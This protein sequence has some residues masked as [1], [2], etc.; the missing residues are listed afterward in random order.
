M[1][2]ITNVISNGLTALPDLTDPR[3]G[4]HYLTDPTNSASTPKNNDQ[5]DAFLMN[6]ATILRNITMQGHGGFMQVLDP[7]GQVLTKSPY[8]QTASSFSQ[9]INKQAFRGGMF[10]DGF[11]GNSL[12]N[13]IGTTTPFRIQV[14]S[15]PGQ[16]LRIRRPETPAPFFIQGQ[17]YQIDAV[18]NYDQANGTADLIL[19]ET[20][21]SGNGW[22]GT[23]S[24]PF[25]ISIQTAGNRSLLAND[26]TQIND[27]SLIHI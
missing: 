7:T 3:Y 26:Y 6:D 15:D 23:Y 25:T 14:Q 24:T 27:L 22:D 4:Y 11:A 9:S 10:V 16:G 5:M 13:V 20:S 12:C 19:N 21:N 17:R 8:T 1:G 2:Q 18:T